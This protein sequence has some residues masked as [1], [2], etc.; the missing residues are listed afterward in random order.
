[1]REGV[2]YP[3]FA[4]KFFRIDFE[5][6]PMPVL[7]LYPSPNPVE[8]EK[9]KVELCGLEEHPKA[10]PWVLF[11]NIPRVKLKVPLICQIFNWS[12]MV[13][14][15][16]VRLV[17]VLDYFRMETHPE[18][19]Y[20]IH[21]RDGVYFET[22]S[23]DEAR[24]PRVLLAYGLNG[25]P[26]P[27][28]HGG[29]LRLVV[30][31][32][33]GYKSV[34]WVGAIR[35]YR[36][37]PYGIK[38]LL[39]QS[40]SAQLNETW[41]ERYEIKVPKGKAG[42]PPLL[43][44]K[45]P[46]PVEIPQLTISKFGKVQGK[47]ILHEKDKKG[48]ALPT[49]KATLCEVLAVLRVGKREATRKALDQVG[50]SAYTIYEG[51]GRSRQRGLKFKPQ[52]EGGQNGEAVITFLPKEILTVLVE[53]TKVQAVIEAIMKTNRTGKGQ[54]GDGKVFVLEMDEVLRISTNEEGLSAI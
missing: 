1:M 23:R 26:L 4:E 19:F 39:G 17:D 53:S 16:G 38:R 50:I 2:I 33:Q 36:N 15:E 27:E 11:K 7:S 21:S 9:L 35:A 54:P 3:K 52:G 46:P 18:G 47:I 6:S 41:R 13:E 49:K 42:D 44:Q 43:S 40:P 25:S 30:P 12:E 10:I 5:A 20:A 34:K 37:D 8:L 31:F 45:P 29:P 32:L 22:L 48:K 24:D 14:W 51:L 28:A